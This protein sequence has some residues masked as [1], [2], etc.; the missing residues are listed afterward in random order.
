M[1]KFGL[2]WSKFLKVEQVENEMISKRLKAADDT[3]PLHF[4]QYISNFRLLHLQNDRKG[5]SRAATATVSI[6]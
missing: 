1:Q 5:K 2:T 4:K 6:L 3:F